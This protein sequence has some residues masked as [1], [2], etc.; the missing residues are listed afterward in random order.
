ME[1]GLY[2]HAALAALAWQVELGADEAIGELPVNRF[3]AVDPEPVRPAPAGPSSS[4]K[5]RAAPPP[6]KSQSSTSPAIDPATVA[7]A[8]AQAARTL[9]DL[10]EAIADFDLCEVK[11]GARNTVFADGNPA[12]R[13]LILGEAPGREEDLE[14]RPFVGRAGQLLDR[15]LAAIGLDRTSADPVHAVYITNVMPWRP[16]ANRDPSP[17]EIAVMLPFVQRHIALVAPQVLVLM[18]NT[19]CAAILNTRGILRLRGQWQ[20]ALGL[21]VLPMTHPAYLLRTP[22]AKREAWADLL[23]LQAK[24]RTLP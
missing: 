4:L 7:R 23:D 11:K 10:R 24:L 17:E 21:P 15:M 9:D 14:G 20:T 5:N 6:P 13:V 16:P 3:D 1:Q 8:A 2:F 12:A 22:S 19:P 18:G